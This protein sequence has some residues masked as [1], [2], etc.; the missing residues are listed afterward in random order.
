MVVRSRFE[1]VIHEV[2]GLESPAAVQYE[3]LQKAIQTQLM[4]QIFD[5][6]HQIDSQGYKPA[7][8][9]MT[10]EMW[11]MLVADPEFSNEDK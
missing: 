7:T 8:M 6:Y 4:D 9:L 10:Q 1:E 2:N 11:D 5:L 3:E